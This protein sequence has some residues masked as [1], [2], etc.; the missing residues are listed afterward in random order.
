MYSSKL[1]EFIFVGVILRLF[2]YFLRK[3]CDLD[4]RYIHISCEGLPPSSY[5]R[6]HSA[7]A[8]LKANL[9]TPH[10]WRN[11]HACSSVEFSLTLCALCIRLLCQ[12]IY[13]G[14]D[15][16]SQSFGN[17]Y[18]LLGLMS[19]P[20][21]FFGILFRKRDHPSQIQQRCSRDRTGQLGERDF[22]Q[23]KLQFNS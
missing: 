22:A 12:A 4:L 1:E 2:C 5:W 10:A 16:K 17:C 7:N 21:F 6:F 18:S 3:W 23:I 11:Q 8:Q 20:G 15:K 14:L 13:L 19:F 9:A